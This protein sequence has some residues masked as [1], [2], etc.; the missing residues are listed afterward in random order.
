MVADTYTVTTSRPRP[1]GPRRT[2]RKGPWERLGDAGAAIVLSAFA[3]LAIVPFLFMAVTSIQR[4]TTIT[5]AIDPDRIDLT[6]YVRLFTENGFG[7]ALLTSL[8]VVVLACVVNAIV[9]SLAAY[10][11]AKKPFPGSEALFWLY[12]ATMMVPAQVTLIPLFTMMR[13]IGLLNTWVS[14]FLPVINAFGVF[15]IRQFMTSIPD[16]MIEAARIDGAS[17]FRIFLEVVLPVVRP[18]IVALTVFT[19]LTTWND[20]LWPLVSIT[21]D[22]LQT[23]TLAVAKLQG[24]FATDFGLVMA[25]ATLSFIVPLVLFHILQ[26]QFVEGVTSSS[27]KG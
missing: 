11:F 3:L 5:I 16:E 26:R 4:T 25:G 8:G 27:V 19:F 22:Q 14:L 6:S 2:A 18:V 7:A 1:S 21:N 17:E 23:V 24:R 10:A 12:V 13:E 20:F 15:L 9:C